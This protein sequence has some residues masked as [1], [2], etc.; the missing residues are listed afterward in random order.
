MDD[1]SYMEVGS[2]DAR[3]RALLETITTLRPA[4]HRYCARMTGSVMDGEDV[5]QDA[6]FEAYRKLDQFDESRP[7]KPWLFRICHN[8]CI[9]FLRRKG[10]REKTEESAAQPDE[11]PP[12]EP[13]TLGVGKAVEHLV[14]SLPPKERACILLKDVFDYSLEEVAELV[15]STVGGVKAALN[16]GRTKL[17][18]SPPVNPAT[19]AD[20]ELAQIVQ[21]YV[22]RFNR[23][24]WNGV[25]ELISDDARLRVADRYAGRLSG[26]PYFSVYEKMP[27]PWKMTA[28]EV[29]GEPVVIILQLDGE[30]WSPMSVIRFVVVNQHIAHIFD[31]SLCLW[32]LKA[33]PL[34]FR[35]VVASDASALD[36]SRD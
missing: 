16:R 20:P 26:S 36:S 7:L 28:G 11:T 17:A 2:F 22:E 31:Y 23:R 25:R 18:V 13:N 24:D 32:I 15:D 5:V 34:H 12:D 21:L 29:E 9:D 4:L 30:V 35:K 10:V 8:R 3:Y 6:L 14:S 33:T 1:P 19:K 27:T